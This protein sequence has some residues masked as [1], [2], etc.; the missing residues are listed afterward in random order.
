MGPVGVKCTRTCQNKLILELSRNCHLSVCQVSVSFVLA[1]CHGLVFFFLH[2]SHYTVLLYPTI[3]SVTIYHITLCKYISHYTL[4][5]SN[6][7][8]FLFFCN[9]CLENFLHY[10]VNISQVLHCSQILK[11]LQTQSGNY[12][13]SAFTN[14]KLTDQYVFGLKQFMPRILVEL[15]GQIYS[16]LFPK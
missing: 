15:W 8:V 5:L 13:R 6:N 3:H 4:L 12:I 11:E 1:M 10:S 7:S 16:P 2:Y 9:I 14:I